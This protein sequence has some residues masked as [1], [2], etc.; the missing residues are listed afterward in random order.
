VRGRADRSDTVFA[1]LLRSSGG[2]VLAVML[3][4]GFFLA[5][6]ASEA[7]HS[8]G[9]S[10]FTEARWDPDSGAFG[11]T[12]VL[13][14]TALIG[15]VAVSVAFPLA[16]GT[17]LYISEYAPQRL[18]RILISSV[19]LMAAVPSVVYGLWGFVLLQEYFAPTAK[20][21]STYLAWFPL[22]RVEGVDPSD[23]LATITEYKSSTAI[24]GLVVGLMVT[25]IMCSIMREAFSQAPVGEREGAYA[26]G[27]SRW[28]MIRA[29][30]LPY[31]RGGIVGGTMLG[32]GRALGET[33]AVYLIL[34]L[35]I[36]VQPRILQSG[37]SSISALIA[38]K[39]AEATDFG[40]SALM[41]AGLTLFLATLVVNF[42]ASMIVARSRSGAQDA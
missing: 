8:S 20:W 19:D 34:S 1:I 27:A 6:R 9:W 10:F 14:G 33:I 30:V 12:A 40:T 41:A 31:G 39:Y 32:L 26:L 29:V 28:A 3:L 24:A 38:S 22:F 4:V 15:L 13:L 16:L 2:L 18:R 5:I 37:G 35:V 7:L 25:P 11:V 36:A 17:A 42:G 21:L 23:P